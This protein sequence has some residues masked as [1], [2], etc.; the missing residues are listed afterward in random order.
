M[1]ENQ[2][3]NVG[4]KVAVVVFAYV[5]LALAILVE[6]MAGSA[7]V[8]PQVVREVQTAEPLKPKQTQG[9]VS[10]GITWVPSGV[11]SYGIPANPNG[12]LNFLV[13]RG[14]QDLKEIQV[15]F[16]LSARL[17]PGA[18]NQWW[19]VHAATGLFFKQSI[20]ISEGESAK[21]LETS[22]ENLKS[23]DQQET[24]LWARPLYKAWIF[25]PT[26]GAFISK[27]HPF[28]Y[29][30]WLDDEEEFAPRVRPLIS[31]FAGMYL[32]YVNEKRKRSRINRK[33]YVR[34]R[35]FMAGV[36]YFFLDL[37]LWYD[38]R[39]EVG[40]P[41]GIELFLG[42]FVGSERHKFI[43]QFTYG[44]STDRNM[45]PKLVIGFTFGSKGKLF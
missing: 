7:C 33:K 13:R 25:G 1:S 41:L 10:G 11:N 9:S 32:R 8:S 27:D 40:F 18:D 2:M 28:V 6:W 3:G 29:G 35:G 38:R 19:G 26:L 17:G 24:N 31:P 43:H 16:N 36:N 42:G 45:L 37:P 34:L 44:I 22:P 30:E 15:P 39:G 12:D 21:S 20:L 5:A 14:R 23:T 4:R